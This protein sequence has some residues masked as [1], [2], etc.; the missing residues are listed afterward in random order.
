[1]AP[2][3]IKREEEGKVREVSPCRRCYFLMKLPGFDGKMLD[4]L[5]C[6]D[7]M[8][9]GRAREGRG[10]AVSEAA[11]VY[12]PSALSSCKLLSIIFDLLHYFLF[13]HIVSPPTLSHLTTNDITHT[14][15]AH[16][17]SFTLAGLSHHLYEQTHSPSAR[18]LSDTSL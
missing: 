6:D 5:T 17:R 9:T 3:G 4:L 15:N 10:E 7:R 12:K 11:A 13:S 14:V 2:C 16:T 8:G 18:K 1:V